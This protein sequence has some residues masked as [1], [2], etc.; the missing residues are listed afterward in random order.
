GEIAHIV[1]EKTDAARGVSDMGPAQRNL[2]G[3]LVLLCGHHH[4]IIDQQPGV[5][6]VDRLHDIKSQH[7]AW[8][9]SSL[10]PADQE[11]ERQLERYAQF[12]DEWC[13]L[14]E[15]DHCTAWTSHMLGN[16]QP[17]CYD[18]ILQKLREIPEWNLSRL[19]PG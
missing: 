7:E 8:V 6:P 5:W 17:S 11:R 19:W 15:I 4:D 12:V 1:G 18:E 13:D 3:N 2:Y 16:G 10:S 14:V 9:A